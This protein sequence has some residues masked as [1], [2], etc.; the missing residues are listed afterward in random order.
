M[1][2]FAF[3]VM[4]EIDL[5]KFQMSFVTYVKGYLITFV[6]LLLGID[7]EHNSGHL[8]SIR[9][10]RTTLARYKTYRELY[11]ALC[12]TTGEIPIAL[13]TDN[14]SNVTS[15][16]T[17]TTTTPANNNN[18]YESL[19]PNGKKGHR[20]KHNDILSRKASSHVIIQKNW[21]NQNPEREDIT[22]LIRNRMKS[23]DLS[24]NDYCDAEYKKNDICYMILNPSPKRKLRAGDLVYVIQPSSMFAIPSRLNRT[25][26]KRANMQ[27]S[28]SDTDLNKPTNKDSAFSRDRTHSLSSQERSTRSRFTVGSVEI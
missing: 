19:T 8:S 4:E 9:I 10:K 14:Q 28:G 2:G 23:L 5:E 25:K 3:C 16:A 27:R 24:V 15:T 20:G 13:Y 11:H 26:Q 21:N 17:P 6:R 12:S 22:D 1:Y 7:A 18:P